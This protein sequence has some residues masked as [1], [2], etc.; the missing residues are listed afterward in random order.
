MDVRGRFV[1]NIFI[2]SQK[3]EDVSLKTLEKG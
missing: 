3:H 1:D 2:E